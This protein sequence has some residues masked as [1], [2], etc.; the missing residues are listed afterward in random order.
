MTI[1]SLGYTGFTIDPATW[2]L[3]ALGVSLWPGGPPA[4]SA[5]LQA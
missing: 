5:T 3:L 2:A 4:A 1:D